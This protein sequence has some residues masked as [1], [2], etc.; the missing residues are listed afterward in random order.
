MFRVLVVCLLYLNFS[1]LTSLILDLF[2]EQKIHKLCEHI[3]DS[4]DLIKKC[5]KLLR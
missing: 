3:P 4:K 2:F 5:N 1:F